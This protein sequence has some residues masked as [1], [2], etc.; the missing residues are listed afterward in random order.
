MPEA[1]EDF[2]NEHTSKEAPIGILT[3]FLAE[4]IFCIWARGDGPWHQHIQNRLGP[5]GQRRR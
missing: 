4:A 2:A 1:V 5:G 3:S